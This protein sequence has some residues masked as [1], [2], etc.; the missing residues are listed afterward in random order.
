MTPEEAR[1]ILCDKLETDGEMYEVG[2]LIEDLLLERK[3]LLVALGGKQCAGLCCC[4][5]R[6]VPGCGGS[7]VV[8]RSER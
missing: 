2:M 4:Q 1:Q 8:P 6:H 7:W 3:A 5:A